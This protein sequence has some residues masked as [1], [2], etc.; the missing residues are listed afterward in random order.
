MRGVRAVGAAPLHVG[1]PTRDE[2][3]VP[4]VV[5][6]GDGRCVT[7][8]G[9]AVVLGELEVLGREHLAS[10]GI[11]AVRGAAHQGDPAGLVDVVGP[12][13]ERHDEGQFGMAVAVEVGASRVRLAC[14]LRRGGRRGGGCRCPARAVRDRGADF[15]V[16]GAC[17][18]AQQQRGG[19]DDEAPSPQCSTPETGLRFMFHMATTT[20][21]VLGMPTPRSLRYAHARRPGPVPARFP[22][23]FPACTY[24]RRG[25]LPWHR[26][27]A[28]TALGGEAR[29]STAR[30]RATDGT[31]PAGGRRTGADARGPTR[32]G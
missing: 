11:R 22:A 2:V 18:G 28:Q 4:V 16:P 5:Q 1:H 30:G 26:G 25:A 7:V 8:E 14:G 23:R 27:A 15:L 13:G 29:G 21:T 24:G 19:E 17:G 9:H 12:V 20:E 10:F 3:G 31:A 32:R 6:V